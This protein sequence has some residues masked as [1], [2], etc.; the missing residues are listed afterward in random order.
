MSTKLTLNLTT[1]DCSWMLQV[2]QKSTLDGGRTDY[3]GR[4]FE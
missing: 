1:D 3:S 4:H 2:S